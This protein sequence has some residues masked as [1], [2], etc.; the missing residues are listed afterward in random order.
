ME[1]SWIFRIILH[2][3]ILFFVFDLEEIILEFNFY[4]SENNIIRL[5]LAQ[6]TTRVLLLPRD[7]NPLSY[8]TLIMNLNTT[9]SLLAMVPMIYGW[10]SELWPNF[11]CSDND[12]SMT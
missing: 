5:E 12:T 2:N 4:I 1:Y 7:Q 11:A 9:M 6:G 3:F 10:R 8:Y